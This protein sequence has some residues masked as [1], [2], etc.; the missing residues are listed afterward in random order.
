MAK[1]YVTA[2][3]ADSITDFS[4][5]QQLRQFVWRIFGNSSFLTSH[6]AHRDHEDKNNSQVGKFLSSYGKGKAWGAGV[7][8]KAS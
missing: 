2:E 4:S 3:K 6:R 1:G 5:T 7:R 8:S